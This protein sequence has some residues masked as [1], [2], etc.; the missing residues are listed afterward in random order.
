M[1]RLF[2][3]AYPNASWAAEALRLLEGIPLPPRARTTPADALHLTLQFI[4]DTSDKDLPAVI[5]SVERSAAGIAAFDLTPV[6]LIALPQRGQA[7]LIALE[8]DA[9]APMMELQSR[10]VARLARNPRAKKADRF[11]PHLTLCR[12]DPTP[13]PEGL[14]RPANLRSFHVDAIRLM[15]SVLT[16]AGA[17]HTTMRR[18]ALTKDGQ[19]R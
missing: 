8:L 11:L 7:R 13:V 2:V 10:L 3:A 6:R 19:A 9:P 15:R 12:F 18:I 4:G 14:P 16:F 1:L 17:E 5:E